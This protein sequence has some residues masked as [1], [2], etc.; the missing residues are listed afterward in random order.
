[1][2]MSEISPQNRWVINFFPHFRFF[3]VDPSLSLLCYSENF[4]Y[5]LSLRHHCISA[6]VYF[7]D[8][9]S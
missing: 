9:N 3:M 7:L 2:K 4:W 6:C 5:R 1:M 8:K